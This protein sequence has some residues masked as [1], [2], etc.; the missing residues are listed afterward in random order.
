MTWFLL[1]LAC[2]ILWGITD[3]LYRAASDQ[4]DPLSHYKIFIWIGIVMAVAGCIMSTWS[5]TLPDTINMVKGDVLYLVPLCLVYAAALF[6]GLLGKKYLYASVISPLENIDGAMGI[7]IIYF[8]YLLTGYIHPDYTFG[9][10]DLIAAVSIIAGVV[11]LGRQEQELLKQE[12]H[13][14]DDKKKHRFGALALCFPLIY[15]LADVFSVAEISGIV[16][17][18]AEGTIPAIDFFILECAGFVLVTVCM[19]LYLLIVKKYAYNPFDEGELIRCGAAT[20]ETF[21][22]MTFLLAAGINPVLTGPVTSSYCIV[23]I[24][25]ARIFLKERLTK[26]Q[27]IS[28]AFLL[29]GIALLG[30]SDIFNV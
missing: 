19:W 9:A 10:M 29:F 6:F 25:L 14:S 8:Y 17:G 20:G 15:N 11:I 23:T 3:L 28:L 22:T 7:L 30:I 5:D 21:G 2:I 16:S 24:I 13:L 26:K 12:S 1:T 27:Y 18:S 4:D